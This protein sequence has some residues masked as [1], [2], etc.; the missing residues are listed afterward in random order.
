MYSASRFL[1]T[2]R[3][4]HNCS[5]DFEFVYGRVLG[6]MPA[7]Q[8]YKIRLCRIKTQE[9]VVISGEIL[10]CTSGGL[11][12]N[13]RLLHTWSLDFDFDCGRLIVF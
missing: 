3:L 6:S 11:F 9:I 2:G 4:L 10:Y 13:S 8:Q 7:T 5:M 12:L 1:L